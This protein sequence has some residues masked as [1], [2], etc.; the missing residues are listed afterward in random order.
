MKNTLYC[1]DNLGILRKYIE[2]KSVDLIYFDPPF[3]A[4]HTT[5]WSR[6]MRRKCGALRIDGRAGLTSILSG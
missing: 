5:R 3:S 4:I 6:E 2:D 1:G